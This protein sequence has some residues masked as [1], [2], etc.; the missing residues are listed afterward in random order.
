MQ[1][2]VTVELRGGSTGGGRWPP[3]RPCAYVPPTYRRVKKLRVL[4][5]NKDVRKCLARKN[6][7]MILIW[8]WNN[9]ITIECHMAHTRTMVEAGITATH[10]VTA[11]EENTGLKKQELVWRPRR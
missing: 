4:I 3:P 10:L 8:S 5:I 7:N 11:V 9:P 6:G 1:T 2:T